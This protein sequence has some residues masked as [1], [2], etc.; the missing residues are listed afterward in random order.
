[1]HV[2]SEA[3]LAAWPLKLLLPVKVPSVLIGPVGHLA[4]WSAS[5]SFPPVALACE[6]VS[7]WLA[8]LH[9]FQDQGMWYQSSGLPEVSGWGVEGVTPAWCA[10]EPLELPP[11][12]THL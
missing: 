5:H 10:S 12:H 9:W 1:M 2:C 8:G 3:R 6:S 4:L 11:L 7:P